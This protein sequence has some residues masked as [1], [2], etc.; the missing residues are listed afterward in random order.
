MINQILQ[1]QVFKLPF[2]HFLAGCYMRCSEFGSHQHQWS[3]FG[4]SQNKGEQC[5]SSDLDYGFHQLQIS[6]THHRV[7]VNYQRTLSLRGSE[8]GK[9]RE[10]NFSANWAW[11]TQNPINR[12]PA[13]PLFS[14]AASSGFANSSIAASSAAVLPSETISQRHYLPS[15]INSLYYGRS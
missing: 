2:L 14:A 11:Q 13:D 7:I 5:P 6:K 1:K 3:Y 15:V 12:V 8:I 9:S 10:L 4:H